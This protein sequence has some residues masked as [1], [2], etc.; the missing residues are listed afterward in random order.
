MIC[1]KLRF[2]LKV[3]IT[4]SLAVSLNSTLCMWFVKLLLIIFHAENKN[5]F[6]FDGIVIYRVIYHRYP[7]NTEQTRRRQRASN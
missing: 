1:G 7:Q 3:K 2:L 6:I 4:N 5:I